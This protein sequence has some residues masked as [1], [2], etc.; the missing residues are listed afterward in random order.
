MTPILL[1]FRGARNPDRDEENDVS[2][3]IQTWFEDYQKQLR[4]EGRA[5]GR[6]DARASDVLTVLRARGVAVPDLARE[7]ILA[8]K[9]PDRLERWLE[10]AAVAASIGDVIDERS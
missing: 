2:A 8:Q 4:A 3:E 1:Q 7:R 6:A 10:R 9:D 5:E